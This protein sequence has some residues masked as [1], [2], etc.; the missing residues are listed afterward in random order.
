MR[1]AHTLLIAAIAAS[2]CAQGTK[3][4][5]RFPLKHVMAEQAYEKVGAS[6]LEGVDFL[7]YDPSQNLLVVRG[8]LAGIKL[9][10]ELVAKIDVP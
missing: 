6:K 4:M 5:E 8:T 10:R 9:V 2:L 7:T 3:T 1:L